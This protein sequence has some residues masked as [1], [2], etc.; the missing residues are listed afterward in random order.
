MTVERPQAS[1]ATG[2]REGLVGLEVR[3]GLRVARVGD[4]GNLELVFG[5][6]LWVAGDAAALGARDGAFLEAHRRR[7]LGGERLPLELRRLRPRVLVQGGVGGLLQ[8]AAGDEV[9]GVEARLAV[10]VFV[11]RSLPAEDD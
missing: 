6:A 5:L 3:L 7:V 10:R 8:V 11:R 2:G 1:L 4:G 9:V